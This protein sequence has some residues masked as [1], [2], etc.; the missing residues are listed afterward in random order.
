MAGDNPAGE[1]SLLLT[2]FGPTEMTVLEDLLKRA[3]ARA[4]RDS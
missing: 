4:E 2:T 3:A 1:E